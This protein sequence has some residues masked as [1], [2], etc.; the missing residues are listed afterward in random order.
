M[1]RTLILIVITG[2]VL[3][4]ACLATAVAITG[5]EAIA[6]HGW[7]WNWDDEHWGWEGPEHAAGPQTTREFA[8]SGS[9]R[10]S[11]MI[12]GEVRYVQ[13]AGP[14]KLT[15][16]GPSGLLD[17]IEVEDGQIG[18]REGRFRTRGHIEA[19]LTAPD[20][21]RFEI[22]GSG[23][24]DVRGYDQDTLDVEIS[25]SGSA[26]VRGRARHAEVSI[27]GSGEA[28]LE[29]LAVREAQVDI[30][31]SGEARVAPTE[32]AQ[33]SISGSGD[34]D[35][36]SNPRELNTDVSG[37][38]DIHRRALQAPAAP[39]PPAPPKAA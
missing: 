18:F 11:L 38:G 13:A 23:H 7:T 37:S 17:R 35:L 33:L 21:K 4:V 25:G 22:A 39:A 15:I 34:I 24:I 8:W 10:L 20:V 1:I 28:D 14:A 5:P 31:G 12:P 27:A 26:N 16:T 2:F 9:D 19:V 30:S 6:R 3:S 29:G 32:R 36:L